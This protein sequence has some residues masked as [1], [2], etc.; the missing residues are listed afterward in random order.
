MAAAQ[1]QRPARGAI[2]PGKL[3]ALTVKGA[4]RIS[5]PDI[6]AT[7]GLSVGQTV[8]EDEVKRAV[9]RLGE[10]GMFPQIVYRYASSSA[11]IRLEFQ[12]QENHELVPARFDNF[13][14]WTDAELRREVRARLPLFNGELPQAGSLPDD[15]AEVLQ[16]LVASRNVQGHVDYLRTGKLSGPIEGIVYSISAIS[17]HIRAI[18]YTGGP[19]EIT[20][21][22]NRAGA[23]LVGAD[24]SHT[25][26]HTV[27]EKALLPLYLQQGYLQ[28]AFAE[29]EVTAV[30]GENQEFNV[31]LRLTVAPGPQF[32]YNGV[33]F[34]GN[35]VF[36]AAAL[37]RQIRLQRDHPANALQLAKDLTAMQQLYET[38]GYLKAVF[39]SGPQVDLAEKKVLYRIQVTEGEQYR[40]GVLE[41]EGLD[42]ASVGRLTNAWSIRKGEVFDGSYPRRF[43]D[44]NANLLPAGVPWKISIHPETDDQRGTVDVTLRFEPA[45]AAP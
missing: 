39:K 16:A 6:V 45:R 37:E 15:V 18:E 3:S 12:V 10:T 19:A 7:S 17:A 11:G 22:F 25:R 4:E 41:I 35:K 38:R 27:V 9:K 20:R 31:D 28:A 29:A 30:T 34:I 43:L 32:A 26:V 44:D 2:F 1:A 24:Y 40:F 14:W 21:Q 5:P 13:I 8:S 23:E 33:E 36:P 42:L